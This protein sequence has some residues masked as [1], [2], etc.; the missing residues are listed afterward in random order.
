MLEKLALH[1]P[2]TIHATYEQDL[3][4]RPCSVNDHPSVQT[5]DMMVIEPSEKPTHMMTWKPSFPHPHHAS[6]TWYSIPHCWGILSWRTKKRTLSSAVVAKVRQWSHG[7]TVACFCN[8]ASIGIVSSALGYMT[9]YLC[10]RAL[11]FCPQGPHGKMA[12][13][14]SVVVTETS[15]LIPLT[16]TETPG[17]DSDYS[18]PVD[19]TDPVIQPRR[20]KLFIRHNSC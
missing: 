3:N 10:A 12:H 1:T 2:L 13:T 19:H 9:D 16:A 18:N 20:N 6:L 4:P 17:A 11:Q 15:R 8:N 7:I 14:V 5:D